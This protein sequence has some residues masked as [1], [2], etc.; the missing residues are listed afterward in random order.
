M[1]NELFNDIH[2]WIASKNPKQYNDHIHNYYYFTL[3]KPRV[4]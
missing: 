3:V 4:K 2:Y 1:T